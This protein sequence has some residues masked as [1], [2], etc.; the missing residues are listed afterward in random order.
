VIGANA[1]SGRRTILPSTI[2]PNAPAR[3]S[4]VRDIATLF[5][6]P[7][8]S[9]S[10]GTD[11]ALAERERENRGCRELVRFHRRMP[12][13]SRV[14]MRH[15]QLRGRARLA[16]LRAPLVAVLSG[17]AVLGR[18]SPGSGARPAVRPGA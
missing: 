1:A 16:L 15:P 8:G 18:S 9:H 14:D 6:D 17:V 4:F 2:D 7:S 10:I 11:G 12:F 5:I 13:W 3:G